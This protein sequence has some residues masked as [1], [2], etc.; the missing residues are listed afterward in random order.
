MQREVGVGESLR[1][2]ALRCIHHQQG[3]LARLQTARNFI[4]EI[5]VTWCVDEIQL[6]EISVIS[7]VVETHRVS[8][9][10]DAALPLQVHR[11]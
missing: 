7:M 3:A 5:D 4:S 9:D 10:G 2:H 1:F 11:V 8:L 6:I